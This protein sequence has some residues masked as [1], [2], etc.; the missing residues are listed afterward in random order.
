MRTLPV[1]SALN[2][3]SLALSTLDEMWQRIGPAVSISIHFWQLPSGLM[4]LASFELPET[5]QAAIQSMVLGAAPCV[6]DP[7]LSVVVVPALS[8]WVTAFRR[9]SRHTG[10]MSERLALQ[11][12]IGPRPADETVRIP[13]IDA[14]I[15]VARD[16]PAEVFTDGCLGNFQLFRHS[17]VGQAFGN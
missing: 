12:S 7:S 10:R 11:M 17:L 6:S 8:P 13:R 14:V 16:C 2:V 4:V 15:S 3:Y 9:C 5:I 1:Y